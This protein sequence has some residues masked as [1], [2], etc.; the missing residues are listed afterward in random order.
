MALPATEIYKTERNVKSTVRQK[1][2]QA[3]SLESLIRKDQTL[4]DAHHSNRAIASHNSRIKKGPPTA[5][6][7]RRQIPVINDVRVIKKAWEDPMHKSD[8]DFKQRMKQ[9]PTVLSKVTDDFTKDTSLKKQN[10]KLSRLKKAL[11]SNNISNLYR[12][13]SSKERQIDKNKIPQAQFRSREKVDRKNVKQCAI[14]T[15]KKTSCDK[16]RSSDLLKNKKILKPSIIEKNNIVKKIP[17]T[18]AK[19]VVNS[20]GTFL[21]DMPIDDYSSQNEEIITTS[22]QNINRIKKRLQNNKKV[23]DDCILK[24]AESRSAPCHTPLIE[25]SNMERSKVIKER[26][27]ISNR[28]KAGHSSHTTGNIQKIIEERKARAAVRSRD[29]ITLSTENENFKQSRNS[30]TSASCPDKINNESLRE[31]PDGNVIRESLKPNVTQFNPAR[32]AQEIL[33]VLS[34][35]EVKE[36]SRQTAS[37]SSNRGQSSHSKRVNG[38]SRDNG[39]ID[40]MDTAALRLMNHAKRLGSHLAAA[41]AFASKYRSLLDDLT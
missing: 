39:D 1:L 12:K 32:Q 35:A 24:R 3:T 16:S 15:T 17:N 21:T 38:E 25:G 14:F 4:G 8:G 20:G 37:S 26:S 23:M 9:R 13:V 11:L 41:D 10:I 2:E 19:V 5:T 7:K 33:N 27:R 28:E 30:P 31:Q 29:V 18:T 22:F 6:S 34:T 40:G 36:R